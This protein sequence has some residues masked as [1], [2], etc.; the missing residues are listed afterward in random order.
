MGRKD[1]N[2]YFLSE[3]AHIIDEVRKAVKGWPAREAVVDKVIKSYIK[4]GVKDE[5]DI[6]LYKVCY[7]LNHNDLKIFSTSK[8]L[9]KKMVNELKV[10]NSTLVSMFLT[11]NFN[12]SDKLQYQKR[13]LLSVMH[14]KVIEPQIVVKEVVV[15]KHLESVNSLLSDVEALYSIYPTDF[16]KGIKLRV[17]AL[18]KPELDE[19]EKRLKNEKNKG[20]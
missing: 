16:V 12:I 15:L 20:V 1:Y 4:S 3:C 10:P 11:Q 19:I 8:E 14:E 5:K 2:E 13:K 6:P 9:R 18:F 17:E 7:W